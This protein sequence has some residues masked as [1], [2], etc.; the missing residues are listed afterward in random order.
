MVGGK[1]V[2]YFTKYG[3]GMGLEPGASRLQIWCPESLDHA[4]SIKRR[5]IYTNK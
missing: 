2:H 5:Y 4:T 1:P 3:L